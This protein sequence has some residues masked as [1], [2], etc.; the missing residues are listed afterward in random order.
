MEYCN[1]TYLVFGTDYET[2]IPKGILSKEVE[3]VFT[4]GQCH[5]FALAMNEK[6]KWPIYGLFTEDELDEQETPGHVIVKSP[7]GFVDIQGLGAECRWSERKPVRVT[8]KAVLTYNDSKTYRDTYLDPQIDVAR[9]YVEPV[10]KL[11]EQQNNR[12]RPVPCKY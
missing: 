4:R 7:W 9:D 10:L 2:Q 1:V 11:V 5:S 6:T 3:K 12:Q 8:K